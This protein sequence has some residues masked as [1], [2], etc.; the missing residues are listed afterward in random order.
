MKPTLRQIRECLRRNGYVVAKKRG[1]KASEG[2]GKYVYLANCHRH[3]A[4]SW[5]LRGPGSERRRPRRIRSS[6]TAGADALGC[7]RHNHKRPERPSSRIRGSGGAAKPGCRGR[8]SAAL[9]VRFFRQSPRPP[10]GAQFG[11]VLT[12]RNTVAMV[13]APRQA[14]GGISAGIPWPW[15]NVRRRAG[16][17]SAASNRHGT[18]TLQGNVMTQPASYDT[19]YLRW[20][21]TR[22]RHLRAGELDR[23]D[24]VQLGA[25]PPASCAWTSATSPS[26]ALSRPGQALDDA[27]WPDAEK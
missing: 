11:P 26:S 5:Q 7:W 3:F 22:A 1:S 18:A 27:W 19:D 12:G 15:A 13:F 14:G 25:K 24:R 10:S 21:D 6:R 17:R 4:P 8:A 20:L 2:D 16:S 23:L 9:A